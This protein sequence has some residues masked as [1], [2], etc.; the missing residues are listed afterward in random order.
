MAR[1]YSGLDDAGL[2]IYVRE[3][4]SV[5]LAFETRGER[6][7]A[8]SLLPPEENVLRHDGREIVRRDG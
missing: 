6:E 8:L 4:G 3:E 7:R 1:R 5:V 2:E